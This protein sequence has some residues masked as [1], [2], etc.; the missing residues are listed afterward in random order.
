MAGRAGRRNGRTSA[1]AG[2]IGPR[3]RGQ[4]SH[5]QPVTRASLRPAPGG[6]SRHGAAVQ[7]GPRVPRAALRARGFKGGIALETTGGTHRSVEIL[8]RIPFF[9]QL[10]PAELAA[11]APAVVIARCRKKQVLFVEGEPSHSL[12]FICSGQVKVYRV[13]ADGREQ[14]LH[15]L[16]A[17]DPIA[18]V[19]FF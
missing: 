1:P 9:A 10:E 2:D 19:P 14:I 16:G 13:S 7:A 11:L 5:Q 6:G 8:Q 12:Y 17:G 3:T 15:L 4:L 18:V